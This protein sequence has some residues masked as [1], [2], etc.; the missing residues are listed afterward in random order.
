MHACMDE[1]I[2]LL[3]IGN[4]H[5]RKHAWTYTTPGDRQPSYV[6]TCM[7]A[8]MHTT[9]GDRQPSYMH[10]CMHGWM[11]TT[12]DDRQQSYIRVVCFRSSRRRDTSNVQSMDQPSCQTL[13][14]GWT[15]GIRMAHWSYSCRVK[16]NY[17]IL[18]TMIILSV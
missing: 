12:P 13:S 18:Y 5:T 9:P 10:T 7:H 16:K 8:W 11:Y 15:Y 3:T 2:Q 1:C 14:G 17:H 6:H 4:H